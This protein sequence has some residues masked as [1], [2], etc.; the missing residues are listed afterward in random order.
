MV[1]ADDGPK[2]LQRVTV[3]DEAMGFA[4]DVEASDEVD[5]L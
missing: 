3:H 1:I 5:Y 4:G 2:R